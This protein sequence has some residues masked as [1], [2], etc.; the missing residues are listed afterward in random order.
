[1]GF[2]AMMPSGPCHFVCIRWMNLSVLF[3]NSECDKVAL[4]LID[5]H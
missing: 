4:I 3:Q 5:Q 1:M 2:G